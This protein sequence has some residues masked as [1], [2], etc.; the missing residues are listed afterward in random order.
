MELQA[1]FAKHA[2]HNSGRD[3]SEGRS[4][5]FVG[6]CVR[7]RVDTLERDHE[8]AEGKGGEEKVHWNHANLDEPYR[9]RQLAR[10]RVD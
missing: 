4:E 2:Y 9:H 8:V 3:P 10:I 1:K 5:T 6:L 7:S